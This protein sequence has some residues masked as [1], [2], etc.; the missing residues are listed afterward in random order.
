MNNISTSKEIKIV[1]CDIKDLWFDED[2]PYLAFKTRLPFLCDKD[3]NVLFGNYFLRTKK[4]KVIFIENNPLLEESLMEL[5]RFLVNA[6]DLERLYNLDNELLT[7]LNN[8]LKQDLEQLSLFDTIEL[9]ETRL[10]SKEIYIQP[11]R[12]DFVKHNTIKKV[13]N[14]DE[15][16]DFS[17]FDYYGEGE[18]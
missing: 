10:I 8:E 6:N 2:V 15:D 12:Y 13:D 1:D 7:Y 17:L 14:G 4:C 9:R 5:E 16:D 3:G 11:A 18:I